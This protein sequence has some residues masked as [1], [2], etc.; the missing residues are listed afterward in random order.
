MCMTPTW[1]LFAC[2]MKLLGFCT[3]PC[4]AEVHISPWRR[5]CGM[6]FVMVADLQCSIQEFNINQRSGDISRKQC[7]N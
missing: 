6:S 7:L 4:S 3:D 5:D 2:R 1:Y